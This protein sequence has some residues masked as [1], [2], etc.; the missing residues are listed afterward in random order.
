MSE[1]KVMIDCL[2]ALGVPHCIN[3]GTNDRKKQ[4][5]KIINDG[6]HNFTA[7]ACTAVVVGGSVELVFLNEEGLFIFSRNLNTKEV[8][9][10]RRINAN[11]KETGEKRVIY[12]THADQ[13]VA[14]LQQV[15]P[16]AL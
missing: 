3:W 5:Q 1:F 13:T 11:G 2:R 8:Q 10:H 6:G 9:Y 15:D 14:E 7:L 12:L 4:W 16:R